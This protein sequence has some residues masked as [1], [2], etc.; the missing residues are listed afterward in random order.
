MRKVSS[1][2][3]VALAILAAPAGAAKELTLPELSV[4]V[5]EA[6]TG[7]PAQDVA[8]E[9]MIKEGK[10]DGY[11]VLETARTDGR[12]RAVFASLGEHEVKFVGLRFSWQEPERPGRAVVYEWKAKKGKGRVAEPGKTRAFYLLASGAA[13]GDCENLFALAEGGD[14]L[15]LTFHR[16]R[17]YAEC[18]DTHVKHA[19]IGKVGQRN[20]NAGSFNLFSFD[21]DV[22]MG[23]QFVD[24][25]GPEQPVLD[26]PL[27]SSYV[28]DL[29]QRIGRGSDLPD[30]QYH[31]QVIDADVLNAFALPGGYVFVYRG[32]IEATDTESELVGVL[33]HEI[34]HV[35]GRHGTEGVTSAMGKMAL[36]MVAGGLL[37]EE[38]SD[39]E[40]AQQLV[41][42][43]AMTGTNLWVMGG[44][45]KREAEADR[46]GAQYA[47]RAGYDPRG[48]ASFFGKLKAAGG[49]ESR[50]IDVLFSDHPSDDQRIASVG[51]MIDYFLPPEG[52]LV[53]SSPEYERVKERLATLPPAK[54]AGETAANA[55]FGAFQ[56]VNEEIMWGSFLDYLESGE[57]QDK[58]Q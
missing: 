22:A 9:L 40:K 37:A 19:D 18:R 53:V 44:T 39:D 7:Q 17:I 31:V 6:A 34:A 57:D 27:V 26:D 58:D 35:T 24:G 32:L 4:A 42:A 33:A 48:L 5:V 45:R 20:L 11:D 54:M 21:Q 25:M 30:L 50:R 38:I 8:V 36:A 51:E 52:G 41:L 49:H 3:L 46:V 10:R 23:R 13:E 16:P 29:V 12:G 55:L 47:L 1:Y 15:E 43:A 2:V 28:T 14:A 56:S